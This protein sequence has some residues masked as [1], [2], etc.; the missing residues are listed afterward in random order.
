MTT[1]H[2]MCLIVSILMLG[3]CS[4]TS[5]LIGP[6]QIQV[7]CAAQRHLLDNGYLDRTAD[8][9]KIV[10]ELWDR[11]KYEKDGVMDWDA[12]FA[13]RRGSYSGRLF[14]VMSQDGDYLVVY[15]FAESFACVRVSNDMRSVF[16]N[17]ANCKPDQSSVARLDERSLNCGGQSMP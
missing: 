9:S 7:V 14:G 2:W 1:V 5:S 12:L 3:A 11:L 13:D 15:R 17:E 16:K 8:K 10:L 4:Q 6:D